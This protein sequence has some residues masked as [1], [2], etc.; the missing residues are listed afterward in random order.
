MRVFLTGLSRNVD[1]TVLRLE[2]CLWK[3]YEQ[4]SF[5]LGEKE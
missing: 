3:K 1:E 5:F 4:I 2:L